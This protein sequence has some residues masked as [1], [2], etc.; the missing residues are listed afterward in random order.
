[1]KTKR[2]FALIKTPFYRSKTAFYFCTFCKGVF[3][4]AF[5]R[6]KCMKFS[7]YCP[8]FYIKSSRSV[9]DCRINDCKIGVWVCI[10]GLVQKNTLFLVNLFFFVYLCSAD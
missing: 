6:T 3:L 2:R 7:D 9:N 1:M 5:R 10:F 4:S 8:Q